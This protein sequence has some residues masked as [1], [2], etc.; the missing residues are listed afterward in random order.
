MSELTSNE[1][2]GTWFI[3]VEIVAVSYFLAVVE[4]HVLFKSPFHIKLGITF[5]AIDGLTIMN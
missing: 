2:E 5:F 3:V 1:L 4:P